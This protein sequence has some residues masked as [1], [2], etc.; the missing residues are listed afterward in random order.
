[1]EGGRISLRVRG[2]SGQLFLQSPF[3]FRQL[4]AAP[5]FHPGSTLSVYT[6]VA[7]PQLILGH[8]DRKKET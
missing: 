6:F 3:G 1:M 4:F 8:G 5:V 7:G 2:F